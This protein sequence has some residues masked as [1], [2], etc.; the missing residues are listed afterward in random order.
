MASLLSSVRLRVLLRVRCLCGGL[1]VPSVPSSPPAGAAEEKEAV[2]CNRPAG[3]ATYADAILVVI[4]RGK[5]AVIMLLFA[6]DLGQKPATPKVHVGA[7]GNEVKT[8]VLGYLSTSLSR[9]VSASIF[10]L[11]DE[12]RG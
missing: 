10:S 4:M 12:T 2:M 1:V 9:D 6:N 8:W 3:L 7:M 5:Q 11:S